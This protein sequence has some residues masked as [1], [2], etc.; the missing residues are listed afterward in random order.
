LLLP[1]LGK[2]LA[3]KL[4]RPVL[5]FVEGSRTSAESFETAEKFSAGYS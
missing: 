4:K 2:E 5:F 1:S 3:G